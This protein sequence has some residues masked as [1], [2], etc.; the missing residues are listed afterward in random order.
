ML[1]KVKKIRFIAKTQRR[2]GF[3]FNALRLC[4]IGLIFEPSAVHSV[5]DLP[6]DLT[7]NTKG[8]ITLDEDEVTG[9]VRAG[10]ADGLKWDF[11]EL[12]IKWID[13]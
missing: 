12:W 11:P 7:Q 2:K 10:S 13:F 8:A 9:G 5:L 3:F 6:A 4:A 1:E